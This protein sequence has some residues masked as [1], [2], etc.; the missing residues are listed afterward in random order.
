MNHRVRPL[1][2]AAFC[3]LVSAGVGAVR[4]DQPTT[5]PSDISGEIQALR[6]RIDQLE[7]QQKDQDLKIKQEAQKQQED[8][9]TRSVL[10]DADRRSR[11]FD[12]EDITAGYKDHRFYISGDDGNFVWRPWLH[13]QFREVTLDRQDFKTK[14]DD[15]IDNGF[16]M[17]RTRFGFDGNLFTPDFTYFVNW[18][19]VRASGTSNVTN[20]AGAKIGTVSNN[21]GGVPL[22]EESWAKYNFH[23]TPFYLKAGQIKDPLLHDQIVSSRYQHGI[24]RSL[25]ADIFANGDAFTEAA[26]FIYDPKTWVR[27]EAGVNH[28]L[29][30]ANTNFFDF[31]TQNSFN[32]GVAGR[33]E[34]KLFGR[35][36]DYAEVG[37]IEIKDPL[38][39]FGVGVDYSERGH[40]GQ[41]VAV[42]DA[43]YAMP[44]GINFY[45]A[46]VDRYTNHNFGIATQSPTG[47]SIAAPTAAVA[48]HATN[49]YSVVGEAGY[50]F[51]NFIEPYGRVEYMH[52]MGTAAGSNN[53]IQIYTAGVNFF[54]QGN[55]LKVTPQI[56]Y[57][58]RG[59]PIDDG[60]NDIYTSAPGRG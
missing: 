46:V 52:L 17:R 1:Q 41:T 18:A 7:K 31:P 60:P 40:A 30:S 25:T 51:N 3:A 10:N 56:I 16:E 33:A 42:A 19:T 45:G 44:N 26:T 2:A 24:E 22:L 53:W 21:L 37:G 12:A 13:I 43:Q 9:T 35:W 29:R 20:S 11:L 28:G 5:Q 23:D 8:V 32:Y 36:Q 58:P 4:A 50:V 48:N 27:T 59:I 34:F 15:E 54:F 38:L 6:A 57:L 47:A 14:T 55:R 39:V 49:E